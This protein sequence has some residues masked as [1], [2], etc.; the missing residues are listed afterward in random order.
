ML[1]SDLDLMVDT[2]CSMPDQFGRQQFDEMLRSRSGRDYRKSTCE[3]YFHF[4]KKL[5]LIAKRHGFYSKSHTCQKLCEF[6]AKKDHDNLTTYLANLI[7]SREPVFGAFLDFL[8]TPRTLREIEDRY[9]GNPFTPKTLIQWAKRLGLIRYGDRMKQYYR[10]RSS[11]KPIPKR[12]FWK[13][14]VEEYQRLRRT[15]LVGVRGAYVKIPVL[16][17]ACS[18][19]L[20]LKNSAFDDYLRLVLADREY[21]RKIELSGAPVAFVEREGGRRTVF[22]Y[23]MRDYYFIAVRGKD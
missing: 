17:E 15:E 9:P 8:N 4:P 3:S 13:A 22:K 19:A 11:F 7:Q 18:V 10:V 1:V 6:L 14:L 21:S 16:R 20:G 5:G 23:G 2:V 12:G